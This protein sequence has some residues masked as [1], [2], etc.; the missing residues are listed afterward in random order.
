MD[1]Q[2]IPWPVLDVASLHVPTVCDVGEGRCGL[3]I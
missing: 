2:L 1:H 3:F